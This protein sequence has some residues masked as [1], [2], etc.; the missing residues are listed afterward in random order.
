MS[1]STPIL[2]ASLEV[3]VRDWLSANHI[4]L[5]SALGN[6]LIDTGYVSDAPRTLR[7]VE[8]ALAGETL[9]RIVN[10]HVHSD[11]VGGN[12]ALQQRYGC[13]IAVPEGETRALAQWDERELLLEYSGQS[14]ARFEFTEVLHA[15]QHYPWGDLDWLA[16]AAP[17]HDM[18]ALVF[19]ERSL[20]LLISGDALWEHGFGFVM[21]PSIDPRC[22]KA[23]RATLEMLAQLPI[24]AVLPGHGRP[25]T[26][27]A[28]ALERCFKRLEAFEQDETRLARHALRVVLTF[29]LL[30]ARRMTLTDLP[31]YLDRIG[32]YREFNARFFGWS[33]QALADWLVMELEKSGVARREDGELVAVQ[34]DG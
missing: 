13:P 31:N 25:F 9:A 17:G 33:A 18:G 1:H 4:L 14:S 7:L 6:V 16:L 34:G 8:A 5:K 30:G 24:K 3:I 19:F 23:T 27:P 12:A 20:G 10:T 32:I 21:P 26:E 28:A 11:H 15:G 2:P 22:L 29:A